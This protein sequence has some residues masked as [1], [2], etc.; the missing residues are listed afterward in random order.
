MTM[1]DNKVSWM[2]VVGVMLVIALLSS[3]VGGCGPDRGRCLAGHHNEV[4]PFTTVCD[5][6][7]FP[8]GK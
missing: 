8:N 2:R 5:Q 6:W 7:E 3:L 1:L 4:P